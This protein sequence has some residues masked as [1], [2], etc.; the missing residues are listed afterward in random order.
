MLTHALQ[1]LRTGRTVTPIEPSESMDT[2]WTG[3]INAG[4]IFFASAILL[5][6]I[7]GRWLCGWGCHLVAYQDLTNWLLK[8]LRL[9]PKAFRSRLLI[10]APLLAALYMFVWPPAYRLF[11]GAPQPK[12]SMHLTTTGFWDTFPQVGIAALTVL[13]CGVSIIYFL[14]PKGFCTYA[15][16]YG[17]FF[18][19]ADKFALWRIRVTDACRQC[20][21]CTAVCT[22]NV[23]VSE[24][25]N[26]YKM[27]VDPGCMKCL[28]CV[29]VCPNDALYYGFGFPALRAKPAAPRPPAKYDLTLLEELAAAAVFTAA[30]FSFRGLYGMIP[31][32]LSLGIAGVVTYLVLKAARIF[33]A[34]DVLIQRTRLKSAGAIQPLGFA[35]AAFVVALIA[36]TAH[37]GLWRY[38]DYLGNLAFQGS[39][40]ELFGWQYQ[41]ASNIAATEQQRASIASGLA[42]LEKCHRWGFI[43]VPENDRELAWLYV[44][45]G[46]PDRAAEALQRV[47]QSDPDDMYSWAQLARAETA[48]GHLDQAKKSYARML[49]IE[50]N[51]RQE[52]TKKL[53]GDVPMPGSADLL[54]EWGT[55]QSH[56][57]QAGAAAKTLQWA[58]SYDRSSA[59]AWLALGLFQQRMNR[60]DDARASLVHAVTVSPEGRESRKALFDLGKATQSFPAAIDQYAAALRDRPA[61][62]VFHFNRAYALTQL[63]RYDEAIA[64]YRETIEH[65]PSFLEARADLGAVLMAKQDLPAAA[66]EYELLHAAQ[67]SNAEAAMRLGYL[68]LMSG[69]AAD[70]QRLLQTVASSG[71]RDQRRTAES[72]LSQMSRPP[73]G[74]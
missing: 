10:F 39:P 54:S 56:C 32:L 60:I 71:D 22:S 5:T 27:V 15:C 23:K 19:L 53:G 52:W 55:F 26:L 28:D 68:Y 1:W 7:L 21:H 37:S 61:E 2:L 4:F 38:H 66:R 46:Q 9:R 12:P 63:G 14:G 74:H 59:P 72:L 11:T 35:Y 73:T 69:R 45:S 44:Q 50:K 17:A 47:L 33:Y 34:R 20:G 67:P 24:E 65:Q 13:V 57:G 36:L 3:R 41:A 6:F 43:A 62:P 51:R 29:S 8:K 25:V 31:F 42:H 40:P 70:A 16:P 64:E 30:F 49:A 18:G 48:R 58:A